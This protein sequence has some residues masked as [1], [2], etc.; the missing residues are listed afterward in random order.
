[1][2]PASSAARARF[3]VLARR[4]RSV[5]H[6]ARARVP[7]LSPARVPSPPAGSKSPRQSSRAVAPSGNR[8]DNRTHVGAAS[9]DEQSEG[10]GNLFSDSITLVWCRQVS[11][12]AAPL[13]ARASRLAERGGPRMARRPRRINARRSISFTFVNR[14]VRDVCRLVPTTRTDYR[15][16]S[17]GAATL[18]LERHPVPTAG[19]LRRWPT[20]GIWSWVPSRPCDV[21]ARCMQVGIKF[22]LRRARVDGTIAAERPAR[23]RCTKVASSPLA[24]TGRW[25]N[26]CA[27]CRYVERNALSGRPGPAGARLALV[28]PR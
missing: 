5:G 18:G 26:R 25:L 11:P 19:L 21:L 13:S 24:S 3:V 8:L 1:M 9:G 16:F 14:S 15:A 28:Q 2:P 10:D 12:T 6:H 17:A 23:A 20:T 27:S 7:R 22:R 4:V